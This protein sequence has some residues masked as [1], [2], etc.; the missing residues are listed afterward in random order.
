MSN[1]SPFPPPPPVPALP[2][3][4]IE[5]LKVL[6]L[7]ESAPLF[8]IYIVNDLGVRTELEFPESIS[9]RNGPA[10]AEEARKW[11]KDLNWELHEIHVVERMVTDRQYMGMIATNV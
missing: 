11:A 7:K 5:F 10:I 2:C 8:E 1:P 9:Y 6:K 4:R 3:P